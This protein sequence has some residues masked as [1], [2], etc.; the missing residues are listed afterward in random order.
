MYTRKALRK[1][2]PV[3]KDIAKL[4]NE[5]ESVQHRLKN[6]LPKVHGAEFGATALVQ[7]VCKPALVPVHSSMS[8]MDELGEQSLEDSRKASEGF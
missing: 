3:E 8:L 2:Y 6:L 7:H 1:M 4:I 5:L